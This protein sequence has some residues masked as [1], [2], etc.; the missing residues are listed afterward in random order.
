MRKA[1]HE[2]HVPR[3]AGSKLGAT[4]HLSVNAAIPLTRLR[5]VQQLDQKT[6]LYELQKL[7]L[8]SVAENLHL[9]EFPCG[10]DVCSIL[11]LFIHYT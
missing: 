10:I 3:W 11:H 4:S 8:N 5:H 9:R 6:A 1:V 2:P 7:T